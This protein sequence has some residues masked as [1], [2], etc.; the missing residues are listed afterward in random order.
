MRY[1]Y[2]GLNYD[3]SL[4]QWEPSIIETSYSGTTKNAE[5]SKI[6]KT[7]SETSNIK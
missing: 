7:L 4:S 6:Y 5:Q 3:T 2:F 1:C